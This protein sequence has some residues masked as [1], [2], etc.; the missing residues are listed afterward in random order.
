MN[1]GRAIEALTPPRITATRV[2][3]R[4]VV[5]WPTN[6][7]TGA[8][9]EWVHALPATTWSNVPAIPVLVGTNRYVTNTI[10]PGAMKYFRLRK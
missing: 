3:N 6:E 1:L 9:L 2:N 8:V 7:T 10:V 5:Y 4:V